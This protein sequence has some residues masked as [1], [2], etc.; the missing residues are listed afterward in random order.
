MIFIILCN[1][2][3][4][5]VNENI[6]L[7]KEKADSSKQQSSGSQELVPGAKYVSKDGNDFYSAAFESLKDKVG[8]FAMNEILGFMV[9]EFGAFWGQEPFRTQFFSRGILTMESLVFMMREFFEFM[10]KQFFGD[11]F[12]SGIDEILV[13]VLRDIFGIKFFDESGFHGS[14]TK[15]RKKNGKHKCY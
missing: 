12:F 5:F 1:T 3:I 6:E 13:A 14:S 11:Q 15:W 9:R 8:V 2:L 10:M 4:D 7:W